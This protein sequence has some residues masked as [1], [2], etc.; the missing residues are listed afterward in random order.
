MIELSASQIEKAELLL[1]DIPGAAPKAMSNAINRA[2]DTARTEAARKVRENYYIRHSD[3][4]ATI[5]IYRAQPSDLT[6]KVVSRGHAVNLFKFRV[7]PNRPQPK[8]KIPIVVRVKQGEGGPVKRAFVAKMGSG[9]V[10]VFQRAG[11]RRLPV[12]E[13]Y[14][15]PIPQMLGSPSVTQ[16]V[17]QKAAER[18]DERLDHEIN[19]LLER[20]DT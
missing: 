13:L 15:P 4:L 12:Q 3:V 2:A 9:H 19:R 14:G 1:Q 11:K 16:W 18:L 6:S 7:T 20:G 8:R 5:K 17:E 10:G